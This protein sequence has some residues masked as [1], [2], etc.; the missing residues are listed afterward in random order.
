MKKIMIAAVA[1]TMAS[2][3]MADISITGD[4]YIA[5]ADNGI[6]DVN[7]KNAKR[8]NINFKGKSGATTVVASARGD[9]QDVDTRTSKLSLH[10]FYITTKVGPVDI[11]AGD[12]YGT[13]GLGAFSKSESKTD[14]LMLSTKIGPAK[15]GVY[16]HDSATKTGSTDI[17]VSTKVAGTTVKLQH[18][19]HSAKGWTNLMVKGT[20]N[21]ISVA[22]ENHDSKENKDVTLIHVGGKAAGIN[23]DIAQLKNDM[24]DTGL[25]SGSTNN[26]AK[27]APLGSMLIGKKA[28]GGTAT[29]AANAG[30][31]SKI[32]GLA[33]S[34]KLAGNTVKAIFTKNTLGFDANTNKVTGMELILTRPLSG[35]ML[36]ANLGNISG[37]ANDAL[38]ATNKGLRFDVKF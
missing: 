6:S 9:D 16:T 13:V 38:N 5:Y 21:G 10:Q 23:W 32:L 22:A 18:N 24:T 14:A 35:G 4:A 26:N 34:T 25:S 17:F 1:A 20:F 11:K 30:Q 28:R 36:T 12:F 19:A 33:V 7:T 2:V 27:L 3:S 8:V 37:A 31:F 29:A 15:V